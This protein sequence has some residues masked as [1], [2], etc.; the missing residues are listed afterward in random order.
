MD[1]GHH[2]LRCKLSASLR[3]MRLIRNVTQHFMDSIIQS[4]N[5]MTYRWHNEIMKRTLLEKYI[6]FPISTRRR[7]GRNIAFPL[8]I[9]LRNGVTSAESKVRIGKVIN[10]FF[11]Q[12]E[13]FKGRW[14]QRCF[15]FVIRFKRNGMWLT[16]HDRTEKSEKIQ[17]NYSSS[18]DS[19]EHI[20]IIKYVSDTQE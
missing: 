4:T 13:C 20:R 14:L 18:W 17:L 2:S 3:P 6:T 1:T 7:D 12:F 9:S 8:S 11:T 16:K 15:R 10:I 5:S 19:S